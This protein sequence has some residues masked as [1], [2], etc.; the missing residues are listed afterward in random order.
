M[1]NEAIM[2]SKLAIPTLEVFQSIT[3]VTQEVDTGTAVALP[4]AALTNRKA[5]LVQNKSSSAN[6]FLGS[7]TA[8]TAHSDKTTTGG[9]RL[10]PG[11]SVFMTIDG[12]VT[13]Y[14]TSDTDD[15]GVA[16]IEYA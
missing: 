5:I 12:S 2:S 6:I 8:A 7:S 13:L 4:T 14:V 1:A 3:S 15:T 9:Y 16:I 11:N 10:S